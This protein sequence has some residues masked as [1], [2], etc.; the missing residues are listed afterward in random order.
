MKINVIPYAAAARPELTDDKIVVVIDVLRATSV[1]ITALANGCREII[2][3]LNPEEA[4]QKAL[5]FP[6]GEIVLGGERQAERIK[7]FHVGNSPLE[8]TRQL[9][10]NKT[11]IM[12]TSNGTRAL[13]SCFNAKNVYIASFLNLQAM[14]EKLR[15]EEEIVLFCSGTNNSFSI[16]DGLCAAAIMEGLS[17]KTELKLTDFAQLLFSVYSTNKE[18]REALLNKCYHLNL[19]KQKGYEKDVIFC[20]QNS[21]YSIIPQMNL[22]SKTIK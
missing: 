13:N 20:L 3:V 11:V 6:P 16:D 17:R 10:E 19:L 15:P 4:F 18:N 1:M 2:P 7:G 8:Y 14:V 21:L 22:I 9:V 12:T 5:L